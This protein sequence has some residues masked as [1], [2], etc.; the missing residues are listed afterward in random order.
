V[1]ER[2]PVGSLRPAVELYHRL[3]LELAARKPRLVKE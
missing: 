2:I 3:V 1:D